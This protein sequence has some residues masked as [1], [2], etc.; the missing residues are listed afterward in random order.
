MLKELFK[1]IDYYWFFL[2]LTAIL[3]FG[4]MIT[5]ESMGIDDEILYSYD[6]FYIQ[7]W[8]DRIMQWIIGHP[9]GAYLYQPFFSSL[10]STIV[11]IIAIVFNADN[12]I[13]YT[14]NFDKKSA[15]LF[16]CMLISFPF[17]SF[18]FIFHEENIVYPALELKKQRSPLKYPSM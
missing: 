16:S 9:I 15:V 5:N 6:V 13:K 2:I 11:Y 7:I 18:I 14:D 10:L 8:Y 12:F 1:K 17:I 3:C 4:Y